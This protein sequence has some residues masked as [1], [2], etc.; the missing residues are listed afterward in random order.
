MTS[1]DMGLMDLLTVGRSISSIEDKP[2]RYKMSARVYLPVFGNPKNRGE[3]GK[4]PAPAPT[5]KSGRDRTENLDLFRDRTAPSSSQPRTESQRQRNT[6][7]TETKLMNAIAEP[8]HALTDHYASE[9]CAETLTPPPPQAYPKGRW[10]VFKNPFQRECAVPPVVDEPVQSELS[11]ESIQPIRNDLN[12]SDLELF[13]LS[14]SGRSGKKEDAEAGIESGKP[15][16][17]WGKI[18]RTFFGAKE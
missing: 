15:A 7:P 2:N 16:A 10:T 13:E 17:I 14:A 6:E 9:P 3:D 18:A 5:A 1:W 12:E 4:P 8:T 11:L